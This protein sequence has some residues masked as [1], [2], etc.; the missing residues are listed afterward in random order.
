MSLKW[1][2][3]ALKTV[4]GWGKLSGFEHSDAFKPDKDGGRT[5]SSTYAFESKRDEFIAVTAPLAKSIACLEAND[6]NPADVYLFVHAALGQ[7]QEA[8]AKGDAAEIPRED[9]EEI[10]SILDFRYR[11]VFEKGG[12]LWTPIYLAAVYLNP[13]MFKSELCY[14]LANFSQTN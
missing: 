2:T 7:I 6:T 11:Q 13:S 10:Y 14:L 5:P 3:P 12:K 9:K 1:C 8:L 4:S